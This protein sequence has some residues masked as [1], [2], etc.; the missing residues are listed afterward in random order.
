M[1]MENKLENLNVDTCGKGTK[2]S[3]PVYD[4]NDESIRKQM[5]NK[6]LKG[7]KK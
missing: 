2:I 4:V 1:Y 7:G 6:F 5:L 3:S